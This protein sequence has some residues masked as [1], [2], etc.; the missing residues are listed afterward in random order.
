[1]RAPEATSAFISALKIGIRSSDSARG[2]RYA[3]RG[4]A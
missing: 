1:M 4:C 2:S 3:E